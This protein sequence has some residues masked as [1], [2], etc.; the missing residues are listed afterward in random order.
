MG[1]LAQ[2]QNSTGLVPS[3]SEAAELARTKIFAGIPDDEVK[4]ALA[5]A[6]RYGLD[7]LLRHLVLIPGGQNRR[8]NVYITRDG[9]LHIAHTSGKPWSIE[10]DEPQKRENPYTGRE[11]IY[12]KGRVKVLDPSTGQTQVFEG[13]VWFSEYNAGRG[14][15]KTHPAAMH[16]KVLEVY[17]LR[18]AFDVALTP[19]EEMDRVQAVQAQTV[20]PEPVPS[21][22]QAEPEPAGNRSRITPAQLSKIGATLNELGLVNGRYRDVKLRLVEMV[23]ERQVTTSKELTKEEASRFIDYL[24]KLRQGLQAAGVKDAAEA[25][26][27]ITWMVESGAVPP[28]DVEALRADLEA[29]RAVGGDGREELFEDEDA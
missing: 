13:G 23:V 12:L 1:E 28:T 17:L 18:R 5:I 9:L 4:L 27:Y 22:V 24:E 7:P 19:I 3:P 15:W 8:Y 2:K 29:F 14:S 25:A 26:N 21:E 10:I 6:G 16:Q 11:D 20:Q